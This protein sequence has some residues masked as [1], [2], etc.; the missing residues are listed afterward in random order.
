MEAVVIREW[1]FLSTDEIYAD[2]RDR[3]EATKSQA[4]GVALMA[5]V[6]RLVVLLCPIWLLVGLLPSLEGLREFTIGLS[7]VILVPLMACQVVLSL[8]GSGQAL[9]KDGERGFLTPGPFF[10]SFA[11][12]LPRRSKP[13]SSDGTDPN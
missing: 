7:L 11:Y 8:F 6:L 9:G 3:F 1:K 5:L 2:V 4:A 12:A 13:L 10:M